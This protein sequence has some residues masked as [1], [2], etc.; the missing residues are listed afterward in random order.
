M[1]AEAEY[2]KMKQRRVDIEKAMEEWGKEIEKKE[3]Q[4][5]EATRKSVLDKGRRF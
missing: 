5:V 2:T 4:Q 1:E 3:Q